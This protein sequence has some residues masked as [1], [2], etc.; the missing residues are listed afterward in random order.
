[1]NAAIERGIKQ[2]SGDASVASTLKK[3]EAIGGDHWRKVQRQHDPGHIQES[4]N[5]AKGK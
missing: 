5:W 1:L 4:I 3:D 2:G